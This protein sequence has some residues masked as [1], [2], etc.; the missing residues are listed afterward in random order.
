MSADFFYASLHVP[1]VGKSIIESID[2]LDTYKARKFLRSCKNLQDVLYYA[3]MVGFD[4]EDDNEIREKYETALDTLK[5]LPC[6][7][8]VG[9]FYHKGD[10]IIISGGVSFGDDPTEAME[11][12]NLLIDLMP[13]LLKEKDGEGKERESD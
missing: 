8:D 11:T 1:A 12:I 7:N 4:E 9:Y 13:Y 2:A 5:S 3:E 6:R 10:W